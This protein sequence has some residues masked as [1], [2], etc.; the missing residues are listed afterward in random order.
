MDNLECEL[1]LKELSGYLETYFYF[2][3][4]REYVIVSR[5][6]FNWPCVS[7]CIDT[8]PRIEGPTDSL[9]KPY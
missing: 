4:S 7:C 1:F 3:I 5:C 6:F 9:C 2:L 8:M